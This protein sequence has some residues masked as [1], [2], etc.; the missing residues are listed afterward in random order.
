MKILPVLVALDNFRVALG[1]PMAQ[2]TLTV[3]I[4]AGRT[5]GTFLHSSR[6]RRSR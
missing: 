4:E 1:T 2:R 5:G 6:T 3:V